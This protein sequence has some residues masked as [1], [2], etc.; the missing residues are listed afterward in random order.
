V[1]L[2]LEKVEQEMRVGVVEASAT[3]PAAG[4]NRQKVAL[5]ITR[6]SA[7]PKSPHLGRLVFWKY[8]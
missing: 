1:L 8:A 6:E 2:D 3:V 7:L 4:Q 5:S